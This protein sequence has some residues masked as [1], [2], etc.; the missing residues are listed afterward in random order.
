M[1][2]A[3]EEASKAYKRKEVPVGALLLS[4]EKKILAQ[5]GNDKEKTSNPCGHAEVLTIQQAAQNLGNWRLVGA[6][7][8]VTLE[9]CLMCLGAIVQARLSQCIFGAYDA[10]GGA[11]S[12]GYYLHQDKRLNHKFS[13]MGGIQHYECSRL[14][15]RFF[16]EQRRSYPRKN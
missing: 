4:A 8:Y 5:S 14:L 6:T 15:S 2:L 12:L 9:P 7:L 13:V 10:K 11:L 3:L 16:Q 1:K